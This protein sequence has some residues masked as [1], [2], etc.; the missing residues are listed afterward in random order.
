MRMTQLVVRITDDQ[1][2]ELTLL[3][4]RERQRISD[5][6]R[7]ALDRHFRS[8]GKAVKNELLALAEIGKR[9]KGKKYPKDLSTNY[10]RYLYGDKRI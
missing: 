8:K 5:V 2:R 10:K 1:Q 3:A 6:V 9:F 7:D 4:R